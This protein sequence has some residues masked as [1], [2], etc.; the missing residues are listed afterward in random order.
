L[1]KTLSEILDGSNVKS[2]RE[3]KIDKKKMEVYNLG[4]YMLWLALLIGE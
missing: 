3:I 2:T 1:D 4:I